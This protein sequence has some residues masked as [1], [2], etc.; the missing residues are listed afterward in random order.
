ME[1]EGREKGTAYHEKKKFKDHQKMRGK[2]VTHGGVG[3]FWGDE[4]IPG[5][6]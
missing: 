1:I 4:S 5:Y 3:T 6:C 2:A